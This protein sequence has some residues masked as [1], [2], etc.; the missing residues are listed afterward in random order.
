MMDKIMPMNCVRQWQFQKYKTGLIPIVIILAGFLLKLNG[1]NL[2][3]YVTSIV[4]G[5]AFVSYLAVLYIFRLGSPKIP[6]LDQVMVSPV[7]GKVLSVEQVNGMVKIRIRKA[8]IDPIEMRCP[9]SLNAQVKDLDDGIPYGEHSIQMSF[10][11]NTPLLFHEHGMV[12]GSLLG[13]VRGSYTVT[14]TFSENILKGSIQVKQGDIVIA[15]E[16]ILAE[17]Q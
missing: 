16:S 7:H 6:D 4:M 3:L 14:I 2:P 11:N 13:L 10:G 12:I 17:L 1:V 5:L 8:F 9:F 15:G